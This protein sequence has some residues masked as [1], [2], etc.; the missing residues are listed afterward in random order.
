MKAQS[1]DLNCDLGEGAGHDAELMPLVTSAN[2]ACGL[3]AGD[4]TTMHRTVELALQ[5]GVA[6]GAHPSFD[7]REHFGRRELTVDLQELKRSVLEQIRSLQRVASTYNTSLAHVKPHGALYN[8]AARDAVVAQVIAEAVYEADSRLLLVGLHGSE[9]ITAGRNFGLKTLAEAFA[10]RRY[11]A[12]GS[13]VPRS[14]PGALLESVEEA[15][16]QVRYM[17]L[18]RTVI[19]LDG[20]Q[21]D[22]TPDTICLHGDGPHAVEFA[23]QLRAAIQGWGIALHRCG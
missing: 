23:Q 7:D 13:L 12:N 11:Q 22:L 6:M 18:H 20:K 5:H 1:I 4:E 19:A 17:L 14:Q 15:L 16:N 9:L 3:H 8:M 21:V 10:D 2:I